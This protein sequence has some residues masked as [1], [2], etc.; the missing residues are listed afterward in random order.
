MTNNSKSYFIYSKALG[1]KIP[2]SEQ[3]V[4]SFYKDVA[5]K[6]MREQ[7]HGRCVCPKKYIWSCD[8]DCDICEYHRNDTVSLDAEQS[9]DG[10]N[11][12]NLIATASAE[13]IVQDRLLLEELLNRFRELDEDADRI[14]EMWM[15]GDKISDRKIAERLGRPQRTFAAK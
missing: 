13:N 4:K 6:R 11:L 12:Y 1:E 10:A 2:V 14:I 3:E 9:E 5:R 15:D 7:Y 8:G